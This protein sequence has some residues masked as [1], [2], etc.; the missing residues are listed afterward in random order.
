MLASLLTIILQFVPLRF[1]W[2][3][4]L[5]VGSAGAA[6][7]L[8][9]AVAQLNQRSDIQFVLISGD[10][11]EMGASSELRLAKDILSKLRLPFHIIP[12][13]H[14]T[15]W[16]ESGTTEFPRLFGSNTFVA[17]HGDYTFLGIHQGPILRMADGCFSPEDLRWLDTALTVARQ[18]HAKLII[19]SHYPIDS[20][21]SNWYALIDRLNG[22][23]VRMF[24]V[25]HGHRNL[26][27]S[28]EGYPAAMGR[29]LLDGHGA[30]P[31][32]NVVTISGDSITIRE[33]GSGDSGPR[34]WYSDLL[35]RVSYKTRTQGRTDFSVNS[36]Y[37][38]VG[39]V[40]ERDL[41]FTVTSPPCFSDSTVVVG[42][43]SGTIHAMDLA[44]GRPLW[45]FKTDGP[46]LAA[47]D[48]ARGCVIVTSAD[49]SVSCL[50]MATG[51]LR[52]KARQ[53]SPIVAAPRIQGDRVYIGGS[54]GSFRMHD[55]SSG[56]EIWRFNAVKGFVETRP[57][58]HNGMV[59]FGSWGE[60][61]Y[62][63]GADDGTPLWEW[64]GPR[65]GKLYS[66]AA[67]WPV[68]VGNRLFLV[69]PDRAMTVL[70]CA[71]G[72]QICRS[73][74]HRVRETIGLTSDSSLVLVRTMSD[75]IIAFDSRSD[76]LA[77]VWISRPGFG[78]D[79][80]AAMLVEKDGVV[81]YGSMRGYVYAIDSATGRLKWVHRL[82]G[83]AL[84]T[85]AP[86]DGRSILASN[87]DGKVFLLRNCAHE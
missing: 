67:C 87:F 13:N 84:N 82:S 73:I 58:V 12:G 85:L 68:A 24:L 83:V 14:D 18:E 40:W 60:K 25:G 48:A 17:R 32:Y 59:F 76:S 9:S 26:R 75:S 16:S 2:L 70:N 34:S 19:L 39:V 46:V 11:T 72:E 78:S 22:V 23:D 77:E 71:S 61:F 36:K 52:W 31:G 69:A 55:L 62:A 7:A 20:S 28:F 30:G 38:A 43:V 56:K 45:S 35:S 50:E 37:P 15:K 66:P 27:L 86:L 21:I 41:G 65:R 44:D 10:I 29:A 42:D 5:H 74:R 6:C 80:N 79:I 47:P 53:G 33:E 81:F 1:A 63:L 3:S 8:D 57:L 49:S 64:H 54:D 4:D 51:R